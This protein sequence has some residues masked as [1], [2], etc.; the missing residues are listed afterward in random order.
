MTQ[1]SSAAC[2]LAF[3]AEGAFAARRE[4]QNRVAAVVFPEAARAHAWG[5]RSEGTYHHPQYAHSRYDTLRLRRK[6]RHHI[7]RDPCRK[8]WKS[9]Y[10]PPGATPKQRIMQP[11]ATDTNPKMKIAVALLC[12][13]HRK[14]P[15]PIPTMIR[16]KLNQSAA[17]CEHLKYLKD[18]GLRGCRR[19]QQRPLSTL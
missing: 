13:S 4:A 6:H 10:A 8:P 14:I 19:Y 15:V 5:P 12:T 17:G 3:F 16:P 1:I 2:V 9:I 7:F 18:Q 11:H